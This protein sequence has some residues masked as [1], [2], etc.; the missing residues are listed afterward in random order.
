MTDNQ[1]N[2]ERLVGKQVLLIL[3]PE[4]FKALDIDGVTGPRFY[5]NV[6]GFDGFGLWIEDSDFTIT[7]SYDSNGE[8]IPAVQ[9]KVE[10][11]RA[12]F[13]ILWSYIQSII[14]FPERPGLPSLA[15][16]DGRIGFIPRRESST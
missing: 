1:M 3:Q 5:A 13:L 14:H 12:H 4:A 8:I 16:E 6:S 10:T 2:M 15:Q 9:R 7:P 11:H